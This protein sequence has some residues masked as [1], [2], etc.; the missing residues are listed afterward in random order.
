MALLKDEQ[1]MHWYVMRDLK[2]PNAKLPAYKQLSDEHL[3]VFIPMQWRL[4]LKN[5]KR[6]REEVPFMQDLLFV[7]DTQEVLDQFVRKIP[8]LQYRYL[9]GGGYCQPMIVADLEM[10]RFIRAVRSSEN[11]KYYLPEEINNAM[12]GCMIRIVGGPFEGYEGRLLTT[13][14]S[15]IK[16]L[17]VELPNF[18]SVG[19]EVNP[20]LIEII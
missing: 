12:Y 6:I 14:G 4:S 7:H 15:K 19:V 2:R 18:F 11:P 13:R 10:E 9:R 3:E 5:G 20:D 17:L 16:R 1:R 8:T